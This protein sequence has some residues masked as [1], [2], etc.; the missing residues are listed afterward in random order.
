[1][2]VNSFLVN[3]TADEIRKCKIVN[4]VWSVTMLTFYKVK[5]EIVL[6]I[7]LSHIYMYY[8]ILR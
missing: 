2:I 4:I 1:M 3:L 7:F 5:V 8:W 6:I